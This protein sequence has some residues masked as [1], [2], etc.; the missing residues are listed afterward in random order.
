MAERNT[1]LAYDISRYE[2]YERIEAVKKTPAIKTERAAKPSLTPITMA[3]L[4]MIV[5]IGLM[6][7]LFV[8]SKADIAAVHADIVAAQ[9]E[10]QELQQENNRMKTELEQKSSQKA[11]ETYAEE[12]LGMQKLE[13]SQIEYVSLESGNMVEISEKS[14]TVATK[15]KNFFDKVLEY[16]GI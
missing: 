14:E 16:I 13:K 4:T 2:K 8:T 6:L 1:N 5:G 11:V 10:V 15:V 3:S 12:I 9:A 7:T